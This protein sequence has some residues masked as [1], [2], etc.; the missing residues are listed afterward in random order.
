MESALAAA[1]L[2]FT[3][4]LRDNRPMAFSSSPLFQDLSEVYDLLYKDKDYRGEADYI[5]SLIQAWAPQAHSVLDVGCGTG[6][7][8]LLLAEKGYEMT[9]VDLSPRMIEQAR[10][11]A[12]AKSQ[13]VRFEQG[14]AQDARLHQRFDVVTS[15][16]HVMSYQVTNAMLL[17]AFRNVKEHLVPGGKFIFDFWHGSAVLRDPPQS[18]E[19]TAQDETRRVVRKTRP[20][21]FPN[22]DRI[23][24]HFDFELASTRGE[25]RKTFQE[26]HELRYFFLPELDLA[27]E[28]SGLQ[29]LKHL[30][31]MSS[32][33]PLKDMSWYGL[34]IAENPRS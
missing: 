3:L 15:L 12:R 9:G 21:L 30:E 18:R 14:T 13:R 17:S 33:E 4:R 27:L 31:W 20:V 6:R 16:F 1:D 34:V 10:T 24:I 28:M 7:H 29:R 8:A 26:T 32:D 19:K 2:A 11:A 5:H 23:Q 22:E 25:S